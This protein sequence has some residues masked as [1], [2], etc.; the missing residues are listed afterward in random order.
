MLGAGCWVLAAGAGA[1]V[2]FPC[3][4]T[5][6]GVVAGRGGRGHSL[7]GGGPGQG[8]GS[9]ALRTTFGAC[10][11]WCPLESVD[12]SVGSERACAPE[13]DKSTTVSLPTS[14]LNPIVVSRLPLDSMGLGS[15]ELSLDDMLT[16]LN[17]CVSCAAF[18]AAAARL[19]A[20]LS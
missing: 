8:G 13:D 9:G 7:E 1:L 17:Y 19:N 5:C 3:A 18:L 2:G 12:S 20:F 10:I 16:Q 6:V 11:D 14:V 4:S 15:S